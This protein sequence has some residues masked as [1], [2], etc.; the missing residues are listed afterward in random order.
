MLGDESPAETVVAH[1]TVDAVE[2]PPHGCGAGRVTRQVDERGQPVQQKLTGPSLEDETAA[3]QTG[4]HGLRLGADDRRPPVAAAEVRMSRLRQD[5]G[6][7]GQGE[8]DQIGR[9]S[10][11]ER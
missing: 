6:R 11:R 3:Y 5:P 2:Y 10:C 8:L 7:G 1:F 9:A 4:G